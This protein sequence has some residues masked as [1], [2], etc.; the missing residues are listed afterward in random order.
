MQSEQDDLS[1]VGDGA[2]RFAQETFGP[3][4]ARAMAA[5]RDDD[6][7]RTAGEQGWLTLLVPAEAGGAGLSLAAGC[8]VAE[9]FGRALAP[10]S[11]PAIAPCATVA[12]ALDPD[13]AAQV[14]EGALAPVPAI[15]FPPL[16]AQAPRP[17][18][19]GDRLSG[20]IAG[21]FWGGAAD[22]FVVEAEEAGDDVLA[23]VAR[24]D[25]GVRVESRRT[26][27][28]FDVASVAFSDCR[29]RASAR[30]SAATDLLAVLRAQVAILAGAELLGVCEAALA[31]TLEHLKTRQQFGKPLGAFQ[32][33]QFKAVDVYAGLSLARSLVEEAARLVDADPRGGGAVASAAKIKASDAAVAL[34]RAAV[35]MHGAIGFS[36]EHD[37]G[38]YLKRALSLSAAWGDAGARRSVLAG[39]MAN[40]GGDIRFRP[41]AP[42]DAA[43]R[44]H[45]RAWLEAELPDRLRNLPTRPSVEDALWWHRKL[46]TQ[47]WA[48]PNW[49]VEYGG[50]GATVARQIILYEEL[51]AAG[52]PEISGQAIYH[53]GPILQMFGTPEQKARHLPGMASGDVMW[54]QGYSEPG[55]GSDLASLRTRAVAD[56]DDLI[57][58]GS[59]IW[60]TWGQH[61]HWMFALVRTNPEAKKQE[62]ITF[63][64]IDM[65][66]PGVTRR[67][68]RTIA[69]EEEFAEVFFDAVR[70]PKANVV[71]EIDGGW[72]IAN[73]V[74]EK[75]RLNG[76]NP[77]RCAQLLARLKSV[78][79]AT[80]RMAD[81][82]F[83]DRLV[84]AEIEFL[85]LSA[86][87]ARIVDIVET[88][89]RSRGEFACAKLVAGELQQD[90]CELLAEACGPDAACAQAMTFGDASLTPGLT[91]LQNRRVTIYGGSSEVQRLLIARRALGLGRL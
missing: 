91:Y 74:L 44:A 1:A 64:L 87:Y 25:A 69:G 73:A 67:P 45:V 8:R 11:L 24:Q 90:I 48:A 47:G 84:R 6:A 81:D 80:G 88:G 40:A 35:Q 75:E 7:L 60:T 59:K 23:L 63:L 66:S 78:V 19:S 54:C 18:L 12:A 22:L 79:A 41:D 33:L 50:M 71:G 76:A 4:R 26:V 70:V 5:A 51:G 46:H 56:G 57:V 61:A 62:G 28:G 37:V 85:A 52:A 86:S 32:A 38:L 65:H 82:A 39:A 68:I 55:A 15:R 20:E 30:G 17:T 53:L 77:S 10:L 9:A 89:S 14:A 42:E 49:P 36:D 13:L 31:M 83:R 16:A 43:F 58:N 27:D 34:T 21:V 72:R 29:V 3:A 2:H